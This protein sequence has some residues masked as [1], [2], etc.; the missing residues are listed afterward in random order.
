MRLNFNPFSIDAEAQLEGM[1]ITNIKNDHGGLTGAF[2]I[3]DRE[4]QAY[5][6]RHGLPAQDIKTMS[7]AQAIAILDEG[8]WIPS[9]CDQLPIGLDF[10][11][12][13]WACNHGDGGAAFTLQK[14]LGVPED[15]DLGP[16]TMAAVTAI[17]DHP[18]PVVEQFLFNQRAWYQ[19]R[20]AKDPTQDEFLQGWINR[21][22]RTW[23]LVNG[24]PLSC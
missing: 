5:L 14:T 4:F 19:D 9:K 1:K 18:L 24:R 23:D 22:Y 16:Q 11:M 2:G 13:Q 8:Y 20:V 7:A 15:G 3:T 21:T 17:F 10:T 12:F 6:V